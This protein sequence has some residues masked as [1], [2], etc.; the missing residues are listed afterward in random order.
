MMGI[1][2]AN[3]PSLDLPARFMALSV[4]ALAVLALTAPWSLS[5]VQ[6]P[7]TAFPLLALVHLITL[8]FIGAMIMG[9]SYQLVPV[10]IGVQLSSVRLGRLSFWFYAGGLVLFLFGLDRAWL[11]A[12]ATGA[13]L[14]GVAFALYAGV[15]L[16]TWRR[17]PHQDVVSWHIGLAAINAASGMSFG[18]L[19]A[20]NKS[21]GMLG[22]KLLH[23][24][25][26]HITTMIVGWVAL[27]FTGVAYRL[28]GMFTLSESHFRPWLAWAELA[29]LFGGAWILSMRLHLGWPAWTG[30]L[31]ALMILAGFACFAAQITRL[32]RRRMRRALDIHMPFAVTAAAAAILASAL[33]ATGLI[34]GTSPGDP[35]WVAVIWLGLLGMAGTAIQGFFYKIATFLVWLKRY[36]PVA[37]REAVPK[38][39]Q[40]YNRRL[41]LTGW[42]LWTA[43]IVLGLIAILAERDVLA[44]VGA[45]LLAGVACFTINVVMIARHWLPMAGLGG[46]L[47]HRTG[48]S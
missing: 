1:S 10:A 43:S 35:L 20:F 6:G 21:N 5:L 30:Q 13:S 40:L 45:I 32:Y 15:I 18:V 46:A 22:D 7:F 39:E 28:I 41:A 19:L 11:V 23:T 34:R 48:A 25:G 26:A 33:L 36:A 37:G 29:G 12:L 16:T 44:I 31:A 27:T 38:L 4:S 3:A 17:A 47:P 9:A 8:G 2:S 14:L 42:G 24:L